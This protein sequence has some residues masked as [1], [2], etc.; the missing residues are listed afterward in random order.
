MPS[1]SKIQEKIIEFLSDQ[2]NHSVQEIKA[3]L[4]ICGIEDYTEGQFAGS[5]TTLQRNGTI[6]KIDRGVYSMKKR[7]EDMKKCFI[8]CPIGEEGSDTRIN[9]DKLFKYIITPVC[10]VCDFDPVRVDMQNDV[11][12]INQAIIESLENS[13]L[14]I[15]DISG[16][17]PNVFYEM[18]YRARTK[19]PMIHLKKKGEILPFD[20]TTIRTLEYDLTDLDSVEEIKDRLKKTIESFS[21]SDLDETPVEEEK[22]ESFSTTMMPVL[23]QILDTMGELKLEVKKFSTETIGTVVRSMQPVQPQMSPDTALQMQLM[24]G[25]MQNPD[26]FMKLIELTE[27]MNTND[28][29]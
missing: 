11:N 6:R 17:N 26:S 24:N 2:D 10:E 16:H 23:Y 14:V 27:K 28:K 15:A 13:E 12:S 5:I 21:Y 4:S 8:I 25:F 7:K 3:Y 29:K 22:T 18:G 1:S 20:V 9:A 19:K